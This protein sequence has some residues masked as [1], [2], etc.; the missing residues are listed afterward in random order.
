MTRPVNVGESVEYSRIRESFAVRVL[1]ELPTSYRQ[2]APPRAPESY[3]CP[4]SVA[5]PWVI[6]AEVVLDSSLKVSKVDCR[7]HQRHVHESDIAR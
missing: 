3:P 6:L 1:T 4:D 5:D 2:H 7:S